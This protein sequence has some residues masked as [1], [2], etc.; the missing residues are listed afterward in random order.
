MGWMKWLLLLW[1][2]MMVGSPVLFAAQ[3][4]P[5]LI[6]KGL[7]QTAERGVPVVVEI[8]YV[9]DTAED[10]TVHA[11]IDPWGGQTHWRWERQGKEIHQVSLSDYYWGPLPGLAA[12]TE[13]V[14]KAGE[15]YSWKVDVVTPAS[16]VIDEPLTLKVVVTWDD[17]EG[18][19]D[20]EAAVD[21]KWKGSVERPI[22]KAMDPMFCQ[23]VTH[24][25]GSYFGWKKVKGAGLR[26]KVEECAADGDMLAKLMLFSAAWIQKKD[27][28]ARWRDLDKSSLEIKTMRNYILLGFCRRSLRGGVLTPEDVDFF[29]KGVR[30]DDPLGKDILRVIK[31]LREQGAS[32]S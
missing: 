24:T 23:G 18:W 27:I 20:M 25:M 30:E 29:E 19:P 16:D 11:L 6:L 1:V 10:V 7:T 3:A 8:G 5:K 12:P 21:F 13:M 2:W 4:R 32:Q 26:T 22:F 28:H 14:L 17:S 31:Q 15:S 9:N